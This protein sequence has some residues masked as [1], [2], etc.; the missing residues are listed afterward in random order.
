VSAREAAVSERLEREREAASAKTQTAG[1]PMSR[2][3]SRTGSQRGS[4]R[5]GPRPAPAQAQSQTAAGVR[6]TFSFAAAAKV[7]ENGA[8][9]DA[10]AEQVGEVT[11]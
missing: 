2:D 11:I 4:Q 8:G 3:T 10:I 7:D 1:H 9:V 5:G 6:P